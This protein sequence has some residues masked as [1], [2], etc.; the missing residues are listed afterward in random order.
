MHTHTHTSWKKIVALDFAVKTVMIHVRSHVKMSGV[1]WRG[2]QQMKQCYE[3][4]KW[5]M[6]VY[7]LLIF[8]IRQP[9]NLRDMKL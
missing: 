3:V 8:D 2:I 1:I 5:F 4:S 7:G 6:Y 9:R